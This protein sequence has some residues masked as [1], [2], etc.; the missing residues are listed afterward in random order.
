M[1]NSANTR[2]S[3][4]KTSTRGCLLTYYFE[5]TLTPIRHAGWLIQAAELVISRD[6]G[7]RRIF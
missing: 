7:V 5:V 1:T 4:V 6:D 3:R 2:I